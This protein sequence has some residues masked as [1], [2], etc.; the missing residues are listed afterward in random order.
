MI[1]DYVRDEARAFPE[2][3]DPAEVTAVR[4]WHCQYKSLAS[5]SAFIHLKT[6]VIATYPDADLTPLIGLRR[7]EYLSIMHA[8]KVSDLGPLRHL[9][10]LKT[11]RLSTLPSWDSSGKTTIVRSLAPLAELPSLS[12]VELFGVLPE[13][14]TLHALENCPTLETVRVSRYRKSEISRFYRVTEL[15]DSFAPSP[16]VQDWV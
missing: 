15:Q 13:D 7:L 16:R 3:P 1:A 14:G 6:L 12:H 4:V 11:I 10:G 8:P 2:H 5:L 9:K